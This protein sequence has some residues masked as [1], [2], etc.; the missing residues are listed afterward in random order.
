MGNSSVLAETLKLLEHEPY[1]LP[2]LNDIDTFEDLITNP[3]LLKFT[4]IILNES[5]KNI[6]S[7]IFSLIFLFINTVNSQKTLIIGGIR[8]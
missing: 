3:S 4:I 1:I 2:E 8:C 5:Q 6:I 7:I